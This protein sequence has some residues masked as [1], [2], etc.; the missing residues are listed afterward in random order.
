MIDRPGRLGVLQKRG[1]AVRSTRSR[2]ELME[3]H[4][5]EHSASGAAAA[6]ERQWMHDLRQYLLKHYW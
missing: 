6:T 4:Q 1:V 5:R 3:I 2:I